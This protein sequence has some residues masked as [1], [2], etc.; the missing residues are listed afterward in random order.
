MKRDLVLLEDKIDRMGAD[1]KQMQDAVARLDTLLASD[2]EASLQLRAEVRS[3]IGDLLTQ[4]QAMQA[5]MQDLQEKVSFLTES[6]GARVSVA[7]PFIMPDSVDTTAGMPVIPGIDCQ[8][9]YD[10]SFINIRRGQY[11]EA[12]VGFNDYLKYCGAEDKA[13]NARFWIGESYYSMERFKEAISEF[14]LLL[15][16]YSGS[17]KRAG[18]L[19]KIARSYEELGQKNDAQ[20]TFQRLVDEYPG[21][22]EAEQAKEKLKEYQ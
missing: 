20:D 14:D 18:A 16:D 2:S 8:E 12:I 3:A 22:L 11:E 17:E 7:K 9:L 19:Y 1:Q 4:F 13:D 10:E 6:G 21:T 5:N 15:R